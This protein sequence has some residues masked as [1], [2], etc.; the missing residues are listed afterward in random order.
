MKKIAVVASAVLVLAG[1]GIAR[2]QETLPIGKA[3]E[4]QVVKKQTICPVMGGQ[5]NTNIYV[6][7]SGKRVYFCCPACPPK[8][9]KDPAKYI[10]K[11]EKD[12][13]TLD[14]APAT[15]SPAK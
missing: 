13:I 8:F 10:A 6:D 7:A 11:L 4:G 2:G 12:G 1:I 14:K 15:D 9:K 5:V 3:A